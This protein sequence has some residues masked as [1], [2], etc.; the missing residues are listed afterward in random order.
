MASEEE[1]VQQLLKIASALF[2]VVPQKVAD[3]KDRTIW[4][5]AEIIEN[6]VVSLEGHKNH[7]AELTKNARIYLNLI[8]NGVEYVK[9]FP[10]YGKDFR[11]RLTR[12]AEKRHAAQ[13]DNMPK[14]GRG[15]PRKPKP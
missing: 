7:D 14:R 3:E 8:Y 11:D 6:L 4:K 1:R 15:R 13:Q 12:G 9:P 10:D 5:C 2:D